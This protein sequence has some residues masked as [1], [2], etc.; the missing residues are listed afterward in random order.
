MGPEEA[1]LDG[2]GAPAL[3]KDPVDL[4]VHPV[5]GD[6][7]A[8]RVLPLPD[9]LA[10]Y[11]EFIGDHLATFANRQ[12]FEQTPELRSAIGLDE[13]SSDP[14]PAPR[15]RHGHENLLLSPLG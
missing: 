6:D 2:L 5:V 11:S 15:C 4:G 3:L 10:A 14:L 1:G 8:E 13:V 12:R 7:L 9:P